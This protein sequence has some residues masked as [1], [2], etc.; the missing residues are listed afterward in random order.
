[1]GILIVSYQAMTQLIDEDA[2]LDP[3]G[4]MRELVAKATK[5]SKKLQAFSDD[6][7]D[8]LATPRIKLQNSA[9]KN[10]LESLHPEFELMG[11]I[12]QDLKSFLKQKSKAQKD[13][14]DD[15]GEE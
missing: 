5:Q 15:K 2:G 10:T 14:A 8:M 13:K 3:V 6:I 11:A 1:M 9:I 7:D 12:N 4:T